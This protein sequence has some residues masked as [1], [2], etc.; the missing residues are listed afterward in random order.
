MVLPL[1]ALSVGGSAS[2]LR[3]TR[4]SMIEVLSEEYTTTARA[5]GLRQR[6]IVIRHALKNALLPVITVL[7]LQIPGL[8]GGAVI[9]ET[10][11]NIPGMGSIMVAAMNTRD[12]PLMMGG[13]LLSGVLVLVSNLL[14]DLAY[15]V[16][17]P[18]IQY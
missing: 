10:I 6:T 15:S 9:V 8:F 4:S 17:D 3:Y 18:R 7:G 2:I 12:Y 11:F 13:V 1:I 16:A 5:K 14:A